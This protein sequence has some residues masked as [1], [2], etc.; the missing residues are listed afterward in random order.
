[1]TKRP[2]DIFDEYL[3]L[4]RQEGGFAAI[5]KRLPRSR[6]LREILNVADL[7]WRIPTRQAVLDEDAVW[8]RIAPRIAVATPRPQ[9]VPLATPA[10]RLLSGF[11]FPI[12]K[13][14]FAGILAVLMLWLVNSTAIAAQH[15]LPG[16]TLYPVKRTVEKIQL[17]LTLNDIK[18]TEIRIKHAETRL[19][20]AKTIVDTS[21]STDERI[22]EQTLNDLKSATAQVAG[23]SSDNTNLLQKVVEL[24][25]KQESLLPDIQNKVTGDAK[26]VADEALST[27]KETRFTAEKN[28]EE[29]K[30]QDSQ[31]GGTATTTKDSLEHPTTTPAQFKGDGGRPTSTGDTI[32]KLGSPEGSSTVILTA[33][34][35]NFGEEG[36]SSEP[37]ILELK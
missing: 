5:E 36:T 17:T 2:E 8:A 13:T 37:E 11:S 18:K 33:P 27:A 16:Q 31:P 19:D 3:K 4:L 26:K 7:A 28:L 9:A 30:N 34:S 22:I 23:E 35:R 10:A 32:K 25:D 20:E 12:P 15:S 29:L 14:A 21:S 1:M 24:T 6:A